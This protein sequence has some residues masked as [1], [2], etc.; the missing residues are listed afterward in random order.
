MFDLT[1]REV[2]RETL[3][4]IEYDT[5]T[6]LRLAAWIVDEIGLGIDPDKLAAV[7][8]ALRDAY[9]T[10]EA[11]DRKALDRLKKAA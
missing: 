4:K 3:E 8:A 10:R 5:Q 11:E 2:A 9:E 7:Q 6:G 1:L